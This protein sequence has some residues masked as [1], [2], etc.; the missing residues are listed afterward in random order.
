MKVCKCSSWKQKQANRHANERTTT[1]KCQVCVLNMECCRFI[2]H[3]PY[4]LL[5]HKYN[6][7]QKS[8]VLS[9]FLSA[10]QVL[11]VCLSVRLCT[12]TEHRLSSSMMIIWCLN[13]AF[14]LVFSYTLSLIFTIHIT[15]SNLLCQSQI[16]S[17]VLLFIWS[18][19]VRFAVLYDVLNIGF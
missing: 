13:G 6:R 5:Y 16:D 11:A 3:K 10:P 17:L 14:L 12:C 19:V 8:L 18:C 1:W 9:L 2:T 15:H 7:I 4:Q